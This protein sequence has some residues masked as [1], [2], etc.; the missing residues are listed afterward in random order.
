MENF[1]ILIKKQLNKVMQLQMFRTIFKIYTKIITIQFRRKYIKIII[2]IHNFKTPFKY[3]QNL[4]LVSYFKKNSL[5]NIK[6]IFIKKKILK[7]SQVT[8]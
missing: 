5:F 8:K 7:E 3:H 4:L 6:I 1:T 2:F